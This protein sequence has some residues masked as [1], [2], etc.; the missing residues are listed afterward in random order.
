[1][2]VLKSSQLLCPAPACVT[3]VS[4]AE[5]TLFFHQFTFPLFESPTGSQKQTGRVGISPSDTMSSAERWEMELF[6]VYSSR[7]FEVDDK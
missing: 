1:M 4:Q 3:G 6:V 5:R 2:N 7:G